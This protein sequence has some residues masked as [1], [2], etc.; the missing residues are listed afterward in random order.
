MKYPPLA[1]AESVGRRCWEM[2]PK[3]CQVVAKG[4]QKGA[5]GSQGNQRAPKVSKSEP[6]RAEGCQ[7][8]AKRTQK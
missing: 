6:K 3:G 5:K 7:E 4:S 1:G 8:G 2:E